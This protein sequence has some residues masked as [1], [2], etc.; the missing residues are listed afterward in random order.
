M[1]KQQVQIRFTDN[2]GR[3]IIST[4]NDNYD[5][6]TIVLLNMI[7]FSSLKRYNNIRIMMPKWLI[8]HAASWLKDLPQRRVVCRI[9]QSYILRIYDYNINRTLKVYDIY[10][11]NNIVNREIWCIVVR[12]INIILYEYMCPKRKIIREN[13]FY[14]PY[15]RNEKTVQVNEGGWNF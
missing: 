13:M 3:S 8:M 9:N 14:F 10:Y 4:V 11:Y 6:I 5:N 15:T 1:P 12:T 2:I 7:F